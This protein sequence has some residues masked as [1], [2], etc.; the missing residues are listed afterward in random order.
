VTFSTTPARPPG[1]ASDLELDELANGDVAGQPKEQTLRVHLET[2]ARCRARLAAFAAVE[3][4]AQRAPRRRWALAALGAA[5]VAA[6]I[7]LVARPHDGPASADG[8][9][10]KGA[11]ALT[12]YVKRASGAIDTVDRE[13]ELH[14]GDELR[15]TLTASAPGHAVVLGLDA[16]PSV[17]VYAP[18][19]PAAAAI[20]IDTAGSVALP[21]SIVAD[22]TVGVE[23]IVAVV[24][25]K[26]TAPQ[27]LRAR[28]TAALAAAN[29]RPE[30]VTA[31]GSGCREASVLMHKIPGGR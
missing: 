30:Q 8:E 15:F 18:S 20:P 16:A 29:G 24:C 5:A 6:V 17:T 31:L 9:R 1:C 25:A 10:T 14:E 27:A 21:G 19:T 11:L 3:P 28:A 7:A 22:A 13:G 2:C 12:V 4:P 26:E 23:R